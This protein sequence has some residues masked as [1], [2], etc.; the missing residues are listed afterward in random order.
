MTIEEAIVEFAA[1]GPAWQQAVLW[2]IASGK[3]P[4]GDDIVR[5][6]NGMLQIQAVPPLEEVD[7]G[8]WSMYF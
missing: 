2:E 6:V 3:E 8:L 1:G 4:S 5:T 7:D